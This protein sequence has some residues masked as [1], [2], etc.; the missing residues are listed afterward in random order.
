MTVGQREAVMILALSVLSI[1]PSNVAAVTPFP[2]GALV[3]HKAN[4]FGLQHRRIGFV[5][6]S[7]SRRT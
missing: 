4:H 3:L 6:A 1:V 5:P 7:G 2:A